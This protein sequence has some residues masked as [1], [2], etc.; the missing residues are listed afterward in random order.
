MNLKQLKNKINDIK[1]DPMSMKELDEF[2]PNDSIK[3]IYSNLNN[4]VDWNDLTKNNKI[5]YIILLILHNEKEGHYVCLINDDNYIEYF[6]P[7]GLDIAKH[8]D[9]NKPETNEYLG[10]GKNKLVDMLKQTNKKVIIN[11]HEFQS[12]LNLDTNTCGRHC[13]YRM[14]AHK[15]KGYNLIKYYNYMKKLK[16]MT[17]LSYDEIVSYYIN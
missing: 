4:Y 16:K 17:S 5:K 3:L 10:Q 11:K 2:L 1:D 12:L 8:I 13:L 15:K 7:Y 6:D 9:F 14:I